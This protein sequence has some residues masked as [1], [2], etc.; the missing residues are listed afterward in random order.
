MFS[1]AENLEQNFSH[2]IPAAQYITLFPPSPGK[3]R[4]QF[5]HQ[6][7][8]WIGK[9]N[10]PLISR[11]VTHPKSS[12]CNF[13]TPSCQPAWFI[14]FETWVLE[15]PS[16]GKSTV[17]GTKISSLWDPLSPFVAILLSALIKINLIM[18][19]CSVRLEIQSVWRK[20]RGRSK[21]AIVKTIWCLAAVQ[22]L[23]RQVS[24]N[25]MKIQT[26]KRWTQNKHKSNTDNKMHTIMNLAAFPN[27]SLSALNNQAQMSGYGWF[28]DLVHLGNRRQPF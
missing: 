17:L 7:S 4:M 3:W 21:S 24:T 14:Q 13:L 15:A 6:W 11:H 8:K 12:S 2:L 20:C 25:V 1:E 27:H 26:M 22:F 10:S 19:D 9:S 16:W 5:G 23:R 18:F 28:E